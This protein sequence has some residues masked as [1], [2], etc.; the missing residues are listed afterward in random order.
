MTSRLQLV[1]DDGSVRIWR[2][3]APGD[4]LSNA[5]QMGF[6]MHPALGRSNSADWAV[7][8]SA[9]GSTRDA[10]DSAASGSETGAGSPD[11]F[12]AWSAFRPEEMLETPRVGLLVDLDCAASPAY[13]HAAGDTRSVRLFDLHAER[14]VLDVPTASETSVTSLAHDPSERTSFYAGMQL[15]RSTHLMEE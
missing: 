8:D 13:L 14:R 7:V 12:V 4:R 5:A 3:Y 10:S 11:L 6:D 15:M 1:L 2:N 9:L